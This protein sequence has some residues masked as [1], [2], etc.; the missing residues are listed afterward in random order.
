MAL[1]KMHIAYIFFGIAYKSSAVQKEI[2]TPTI[3]QIRFALN[4]E[5]ILL[6][7]K[8]LDNS[9]RK[10]AF[11]SIFFVYEKYVFVVVNHK[12]VKQTNKQFLMQQAVNV[13]SLRACL[14]K[15]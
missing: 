10:K 1:Q 5:I 8:M 11:I 14:E 3:E 15:I 12:C 2:L 4:N 7:T 6:Q 9:F 13:F